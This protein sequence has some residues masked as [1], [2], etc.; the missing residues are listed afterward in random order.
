MARSLQGAQDWAQQEFATADL[1]DPRR[2]QRLVRVAGAL[3]GK[4]RGTLPGSFSNWAELKAAYRLLESPEVSHE[5]IS[6]PHWQRT[7]DRCREPGAYLLI[8]DS[9]SLD[10]T[11]HPGAQGL[12][13]IGNDQGRGLHVHTTLAVRVE[14]WRQEQEPEVTVAGLFGQSCWARTDPPKRGLEKKL[15]RLRAYLSRQPSESPAR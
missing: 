1:G 4:P 8:E 11:F 13:R 9:T 12:G 2:I 3:A 5:K 10:F 6:Q 15:D 7:H 14:G